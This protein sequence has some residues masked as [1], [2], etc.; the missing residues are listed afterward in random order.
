MADDKKISQFPEIT[1][2]EAD[3]IL[4]IVE[5]SDPSETKKI[6]YKNLVNQTVVVKTADYTLTSSDGSILGDATSNPFTITLPLASANTGKIFTLKKTDDS[7]NIITVKGDG[8]EKIDDEST[9][10]LELEGEFVRIVSDGNNWQ[11]IAE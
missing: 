11:V 10:L 1:T 8:I 7:V 5:E 4:P 9:Y 6:K 2:H 3:D